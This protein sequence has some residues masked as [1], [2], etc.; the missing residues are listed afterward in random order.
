MKKENDD[1]IFKTL[2]S[3]YS[4]IQDFIN[5]K[6]TDSILCDKI[7]SSIN[8]SHDDFKFEMSDFTIENNIIILYYGKQKKYVTNYDIFKCDI[9]ELKKIDNLKKLK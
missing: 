1:L 2:L 7:A 9:N 8:N 5:L 4:D 3:L 6:I